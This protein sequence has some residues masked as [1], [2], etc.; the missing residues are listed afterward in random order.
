MKEPR[1]A[2]HLFTLIELLVVIA[3]L[4]V[5][6]S[7][8]LPALSQARDKSKSIKC[9]GNLKQL[10]LA[11]MSYCGDYT[12]RLPAINRST[13]DISNCGR[14]AMTM[15]APYL[16]GA[17][18]ASGN[19]L[20]NTPVFLCPSAQNLPA[21]NYAWSHY[22]AGNA[23][24]LPTANS[25]TRITTPSRM[26]CLVD[27]NSH[28]TSYWD[29]VYDLSQKCID[30]RHSGAPNVLCVD[31]HVERVQPTTFIAHGYSIFGGGASW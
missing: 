18:D 23:W 12:D 31:A 4:S 14:Y 7:M 28:V 1:R 25:L 6:M 21:N 30:P 2:C 8:L 15:I 29:I 3:I 27:A 9:Q 13:S 24:E 5:L 20:I 22:I 10:G 26:L 16:S 17:K 11:I 19:Y